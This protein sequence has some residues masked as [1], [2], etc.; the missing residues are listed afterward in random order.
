MNAKR[1]T[2]L[3]LGLVLMALLTC[4]CIVA[5]L[6]LGSKSLP[7]SAIWQ[8]YW[9]GDQGSYY[10]LVINAREPRTLIG[11]MAG[12]ALALAGTVTQGLLRN[13]LGDPGLLGINAGAATAVVCFSFIPALDILP[14]FWTAFIGASLSTL[15]FYLLSGGPRNTNPVRLVLTGASINICLF[16]LVQGI[17][18][19]NAQAMDNYRFWTIGSLS[20]MSLNEASLLIPYLL[21]AVVVTLSLSASLN[22]MVFGEG[23]ASSLGA[24]V[25]RTRILS[26]VMVTMLAA[27]ATA[28]AGPIAFIGLA[29]PH[30]M[31]ALVGSDFRW[32][33]P[34]CLFAG[35]CLLLISDVV[36]RLLIAPQEIMVGII[37]AGM[38][39]PLLYLVAKHRSQKIMAE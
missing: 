19:I 39:A 25:A 31:R 13:P 11:L 17:V 34:Y 33:L 29:A 16:A 32:L 8:H 2:A 26:L 38:G 22:V 30:L 14:R 21:V 3:I 37:T 35:P 18:L 28:M 24:N 12:A 23:I 1:R 5:S 7:L 36:A 20:A 27:T 6:S 4:L 9:L 15:L 10:D